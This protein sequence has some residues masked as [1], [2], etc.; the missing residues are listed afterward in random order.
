ME[1]QRH[2][3]LTELFER[4]VELPPEAR[5]RFIET[6][7]EDAAI[8][9]EL[10]SL[11]ATY[12]KTPDLLDRLAGEMMPAV[13]Q[14]VEED[15]VKA[16]ETNPRPADMTRPDRIGPYRILEEVGE[17]GMGIVYLAEQKAPL[18]RRVAIKVIKLGMDTRQVIARFEAERQALAVMDHPA[19][20]TVFDGGATDDGRPYFA[21]EYV[22]GE[23]I[24]KYCDRRRLTMPERLELFTQVCDGVQHAHQKG[25]VHRD[26]KPSNVLVSVQDD[27]AG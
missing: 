22:K 15:F 18:R 27:R 8:R 9:L 23:P 24:T 14:A 12:E 13:L 11:L 1:S 17:G 26:L 3:R 7:S 5:G 4:A 10:K 19:I 21:M 2:D 16:D 6:C 25:I 20:A